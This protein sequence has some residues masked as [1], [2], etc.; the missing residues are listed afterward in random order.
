M[1]Y[2]LMLMALS[3]TAFAGYDKKAEGFYLKH[4]SQVP[5][6]QLGKCQNFNG[7]LYRGGHPILEDEKWIKKLKQEGVEA[8][9][10]LRNEAP[11]NASE[12]AIK[13]GFKY[14]LVRLSGTKNSQEVKDK[15]FKTVE[16]VRTSSLK[17]FIH[18]QRGEDRTGVFIATLRDCP[19]WKKEFKDFGGTLYPALKR[20]MEK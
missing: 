14:T 1:K 6:Y 17:T 18:C 13:N 3:Q 10:D 16:E 20:I 8:I 7:R 2:L 19:Q 5:D 4:F 15:F 12:L 11:S 9:V